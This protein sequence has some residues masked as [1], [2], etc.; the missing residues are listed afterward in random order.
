M[1]RKSVNRIVDRVRQNRIS[2]KSLQQ[3][4]LIERLERENLSHRAAAVA[5]VPEVGDQARVRQPNVRTKKCFIFRFRKLLIFYIHF[6]ADKS[7]DYEIHKSENSVQKKRHY[8][9]NKDSSRSESPEKLRDRR[10]DR[11][12][13]RRSNSRTRRNS[14]TRNRSRNRSRS[15][16]R[17][18]RMDR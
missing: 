4:H 9:T 3:K 15:L 2:A 17:D 12:F 7:K 10:N 6:S 14:W 18:N 1:R 11:S 8:R 16:R 5:A 13:N